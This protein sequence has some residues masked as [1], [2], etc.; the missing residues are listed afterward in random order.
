M[1]EFVLTWKV[2]VTGNGVPL[3]AG[4]RQCSTSRVLPAASSTPLAMIGSRSV[5]AMGE[6]MPSRTRLERSARAELGALPPNVQ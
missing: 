5:D 3:V 4:N 6:A 2:T 1:P